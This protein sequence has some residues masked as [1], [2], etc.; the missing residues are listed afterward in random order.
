MKI[1]SANS[2]TAVLDSVYDFVI[3]RV[4]L[5]NAH[6]FC[7]IFIILCDWGCEGEKKGRIIKINLLKSF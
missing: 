3:W 1:I 4:E 2:I 5:Q 7:K 6:M